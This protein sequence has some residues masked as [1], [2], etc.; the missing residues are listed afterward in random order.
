ME[1]VQ[2]WA[3]VNKKFDN[4]PYCPTVDY[5]NPKE[6]YCDLNMQNSSR[7]YVEESEEA[8]Q[9]LLENE[10]SFSSERLT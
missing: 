2:L 1:N 6:M 10:E 3:L 4:E 7:F 8:S 9:L 5:D